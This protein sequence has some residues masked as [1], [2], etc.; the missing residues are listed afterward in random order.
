MDCFGHSL[1]A[2]SL[3]GAI[4]K[5]CVAPFSR[6]VALR[7]TQSLMDEVASINKTAESLKKTQSLMLAKPSNQSLK[8]LVKDIVKTEGLQA[9][10]RGNTATL[11]HRACSSGIA[12][13]TISL[14]QAWMPSN[15]LGPRESL[16]RKFFVN[17]VACTCSISI[18]HPL[19]VVKTRLFTERGGSQSRYYK[20]TWTAICKIVRDEGPR[21]FSRGLGLA[22][23]SAVPTMACSFSF[24]DIFRG[25]VCK[26]EPA[27]AWQIAGCGGLSTS[28]AS[29]LLF[30]LDLLKRRMQLV[31]LR[32]GAEVH[33]CWRDAACHI[34]HVEGVP[35]FYRGLTLELVKVLPGGAIMF[36]ANDQILAQLRAA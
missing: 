13:S 12:F 7:Q 23:A 6:L 35:G 15:Y 29:T 18:S 14:C 8:H 33:G 19:D 24:F 28:C 10:W 17:S 31:G 5:T 30:P 1:V 32:G 4:S 9:F 16:T 22:L 3:A 26:E 36:L 34:F 2:G 27:A 11:L 20:G 25:M 21:G